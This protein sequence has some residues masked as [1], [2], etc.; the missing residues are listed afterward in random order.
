[1][2]GYCVGWTF[3]AVVVT[4]S[5]G[6]G[7]A[8]AADMAVKALPSKAPP[9]ADY[10]WA[11]FYIGGNVGAIGGGGKSVHQCTQQPKRMD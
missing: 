2:R 9:A 8:M 11:G 10:G 6:L 7:A 3:A 4:G 1:M 5:C